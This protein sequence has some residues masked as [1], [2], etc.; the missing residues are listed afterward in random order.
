MTKI[1]ADA[2]RSLKVGAAV[3]AS[4][5]SPHAQSFSGVVASIGAPDAQTHSVAVRVS[6]ADPEGMLKAGT[7]VSLHI[8]AQ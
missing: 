1:G 8:P 5:G 7:A 3:M 6:L 2:A 4:T